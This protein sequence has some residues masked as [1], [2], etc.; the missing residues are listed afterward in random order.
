MRSILKLTAFFTALV[1]VLWL[2]GEYFNSPDVD[3]CAARAEYCRKL[4]VNGE[5]RKIEELIQKINCPNSKVCALTCLYAIKPDSR[6]QEELL[7]LSQIYGIEV[8]ISEIDFLRLLREIKTETDFSEK[9]M[10]K[11]MS[12]ANALPFGGKK[13]LAYVLISESYAGVLGGESKSRVLAKAMDIFSK[14]SPVVYEREM[15]LAGDSL[16]RMGEAPHFMNLLAMMNVSEDLIFMV[17]DG[18]QNPKILAEYKRAVKDK[19]F[20]TTHRHLYSAMGQSARMSDLNINSMSPE[21]FAQYLPYVGSS[22]YAYWGYEGFHTRFRLAAIAYIAYRYGLNDIYE[23]FAD[24]SIENLELDCIKVR[25]TVYCTYAAKA[26]GRIGDLKR[27]EK[28]V[29]SLPLRVRSPTIRRVVPYFEDSA[30]E[31]LR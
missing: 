29:E 21:E 9:S 2:S 24:E 16:I 19:R 14:S 3:L 15:L 8:D 12:L 22:F 25:K 1:V 28:V 30:M 18:V 10:L 5:S 13:A 11:K 26:F 6:V 27:M 17:Y 23:Y 4:A 7:N 20:F 31:L